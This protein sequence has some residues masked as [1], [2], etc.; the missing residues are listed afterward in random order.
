MLRSNRD[1]QQNYEF[2]SIEDLVPADHMLRKIDK[3]IDFSFIDE[4]VRPLY[5][6]DNGRPAVDPMVLFK[7]I[8]L[9]YFYGIRSERQL[10]REIQ[11]NLAYRW[12]LGLGLT[13]RVP[14][15]S[16]I[17]WNRRTRFKD[18]TVFQDVFDEIVLQAISHRMVGGRVLISDS[19][20]V[21]ASA[22]KHKYTKQQVQQNTKAYIEELNAAVEADRKAH[23]KK[24]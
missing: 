22:N 4:K 18:T 15:H 20:H 16:T 17:S 2:V 24:P 19:T 1:K 13:D 3:H 11:T 14:D 9:G 5:C 23:G 6:Q 21:K 8:F 7:M 10:E 12:F